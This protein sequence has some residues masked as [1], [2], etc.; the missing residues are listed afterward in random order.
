M[1]IKIFIPMALILCLAFSL[2]ACG[3]TANTTQTTA[4][5]E[6]TAPVTT[7]AATEAEKTTEALTTAPAETEA[8]TEAADEAAFTED[9]AVELVKNS[10]TFGDEYTL[11]PM[12]LVDINGTEYF[13]VDLRMYHDGVSTYIT[14]YFVT[15][16]GEEIFTGYT[17]D[18]VSYISDSEPTI[19]VNEDN[20][21]KIVNAAYDF[22]EDCFLKLR[23]TEV[24]DGTTYYAV[25]LMKS[26]EYNTTYLSTY[27]VS[28]TGNI[29]LGYYAGGE[30]FLSE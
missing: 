6:T 8:E 20:A 2:C 11:I 18:G 23:G 9:D 1:K 17:M 29:V 4:P 22:E 5:A 10:Y 30:A 16:D 26:L 19:D 24:I 3:T 13:A 21:V 15:T 14:S 12:G 25:D 28:E 27:F 7:A